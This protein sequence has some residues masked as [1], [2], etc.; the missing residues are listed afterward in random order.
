[1]VNTAYGKMYGKQNS[2]LD[3]GEFIWAKGDEFRLPS[4]ELGKPR[5]FE[6]KE[7]PND[8]A[9]GF[10][11]NGDV[12]FSKTTINPETGNVVADDVEP[13]AKAN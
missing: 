6:V 7:G 3:K 13:Y 12:V 2:W 11:R 10:I 9:R 8:T 5:L 4:F 1:M